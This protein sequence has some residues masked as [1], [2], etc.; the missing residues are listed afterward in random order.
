MTLRSVR[1]SP[2]AASM[3]WTLALFAV[4][5]T[6]PPP[7]FAAAANPA[8]TFVQ[9]N[10]DRGYV[11]LNNTSLFADQRHSQFRNFMLSVIEIKRIGLFTLAQYAK[12]ASNADT[13]ALTNA[14]TSY[15]VAAYA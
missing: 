13:E 9:Q 3:L 15:A 11:I 10:I 1:L 12:G 8:E 4:F 6:C 7:A 2:W 14:L 5:V